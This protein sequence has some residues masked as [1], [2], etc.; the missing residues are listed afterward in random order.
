[1]HEFNQR[2]LIYRTGMAYTLKKET[3]LNLGDMMGDFKDKWDLKTKEL[4]N[5]Q[6]YVS[7]TAYLPNL[8]HTIAA[9]LSQIV[10]RKLRVNLTQGK[11]KLKK[12]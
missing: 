8:S 10:G 12:M 4:Y 1:M 7:Y 9:L 5:E 3:I 11:R 2:A 6:M